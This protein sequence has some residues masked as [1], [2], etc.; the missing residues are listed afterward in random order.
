LSQRQPNL[1][2]FGTEDDKKKFAELVE[3]YKPSA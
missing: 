2:R 1:I 3:K